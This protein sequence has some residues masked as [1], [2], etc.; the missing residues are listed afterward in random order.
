MAHNDPRHPE[1]A[2]ASQDVEPAPVVLPLKKA[3]TVG[4]TKAS[5]AATSFH[6]G[7]GGEGNIATKSGEGEKAHESLLG[8]LLGKKEAVAVEKK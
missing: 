4:S 1:L 8:G 5:A 2:R 7:R 3:G 6:V